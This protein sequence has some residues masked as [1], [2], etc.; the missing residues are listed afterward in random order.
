MEISKKPRIRFFVATIFPQIIECYCSYGI[1]NKAI[2]RGLIEVKPLNL[3]EFADNPRQVDDEPFGGVPGMV[4]K[5][6][7]IFRAYEY[8]VSN[9]GKPYVLIT[10]PW[11]EKINQNLLEELKNKENLFIICGRYEGVDE[12]V[13]TIVDKEISLGD[14]VLSGGELPALV[15]IDGTTRLLEGVLS[16]PQSFEEDSF[17]RKWLG[18]PVYT[19]P[20]EYRGMKVPEVLVS[21]NHQLIELWKLFK[22]IE[23]TYK[24]RPDLIK[25]EKLSPLEREIL[26]AI[27][28]GW[29]FETFLKYTKRIKK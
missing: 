7:P 18:Y 14:F 23:Q 17:S 24:K 22:R 26:E 21:G 9:F 6:E 8:V 15:L 20:R 13:K 5:P 12:R 4:L 11:G 19:R 10:E 28:R 29:D 27:K 16:E 1:V 2:K 3:R 25:E